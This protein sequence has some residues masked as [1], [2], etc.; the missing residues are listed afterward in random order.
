MDA[1]ILIMAGV[2]IWVLAVRKIIEESSHEDI[3]HTRIIDPKR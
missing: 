2:S 3:H 1:A